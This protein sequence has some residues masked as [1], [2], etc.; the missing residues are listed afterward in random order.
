M[1]TITI[2]LLLLSCWIG[3]SLKSLQDRARQE[4]NLKA[5]EYW[6]RREQRKRGYEE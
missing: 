5:L 4:R 3:L 6:E 2:L 1:I